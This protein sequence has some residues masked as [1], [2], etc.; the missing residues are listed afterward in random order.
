MK[1]KDMARSMGISES[2]YWLSWFLY[3]LIGLTFVTI[4]QALLLTYGV[5]NYSQF[6]PIFI[7]LWLYGLALFGYIAFLQT[8][9][10]KPTLASIVGSLIFFVSSFLDIIVSDNYV[11][12]HSKVLASFFPSVAI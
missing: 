6:G 1:T 8:F 11:A 7:V 10:T 3:Y 12:E 5:F 4:C 9:F 2:S